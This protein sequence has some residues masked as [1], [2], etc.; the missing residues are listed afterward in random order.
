M[1]D[2][3]TM[4]EF[5]LQLVDVKVKVTVAVFMETFVINLVSS[6]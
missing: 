5:V 1:L 3:H 2:G 6:F 4:N